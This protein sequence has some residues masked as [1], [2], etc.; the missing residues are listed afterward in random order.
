MP[1]HLPWR[2]PQKTVFHIKL[3]TIL[4]L[5]HP[6]IEPAPASPYFQQPGLH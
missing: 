6:R 2:T 4:Q 1:N 5:Q 3:R